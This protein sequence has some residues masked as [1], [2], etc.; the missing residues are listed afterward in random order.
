MKRFCAFFAL[1]LTV[2]ALAV[3]ASAN[4][5]FGFLQEWGGDGTDAGQLHYPEGVDIG[6]NGHVYVGEYDGNRVDEFTSTG[7]FVQAWGWGVA[8]GAAQFEKCTT[9]SG[10]QA[11]I[12]GSGDGQFDTV[13]DLGVHPVTGD[14]YAL[15]DGGE[16]I[17]QF[18]ANGNFI[19]KWGQGGSAE[20]QFSGAYGMDVTGDAIYVA[21]PGNNRVQQFDP[22][23][24]F[25]RMWG[26]GVD[27]GTAAFQVC[28]SGCQS[29]ISGSG[30]GQLTGDNAVG[31][32]ANGD[33]YVG[34]G[35]PDVQRFTGTGSF[36]SRFGSSGN[37]PGQ[38]DQIQGVAFD[39]AGNLWVADSA[40]DRIQQL[41]A[42][43]SFL[44]E[45]GSS[46]SDPGQFDNLYSIHFDCRGN[47]YAADLD[48]H[49]IQ[50]LGEP[51]L[52]EPP[53]ASS[54]PGPGPG[55]GGPTADK[56]PP[57]QTVVVAKRQKLSK[58]SIS[59]TLN[60]AGT[61]TLDGSM[62]VPG[63]SKRLKFKRISKNAAANQKLTLKPK[64]SKRNAAK[65]KRALRRGKKPTAKF[66]LKAID[67]A[68]NSTTANVSVKLKR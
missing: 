7:G 56:T 15:E 1:A 17:Q 46:G 5:A 8:T 3:P 54:N 10:C 22:A 65:V 50:K 27:D 30:N 38:F 9:A 39:A 67:T 19:R 2:T 66:K 35:N 26:W 33:V 45:F 43:G 61:I 51:G 49:R 53:C 62:N 14:V 12:S 34:G 59:V 63:A 64:L 41:T 37:G 23:G 18:D 16:R 42:T 11:A 55:P 24:N 32:A 48:D 40:N 25:V 47:L 52:G 57:K 60:E 44:S 28:T 21:D 29:G 13:G 68:G 4:A 36:I 31:V 6:P 58:L 20:G